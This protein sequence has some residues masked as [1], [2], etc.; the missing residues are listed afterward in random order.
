MS[1]TRVLPLC[2]LSIDRDTASS[3]DLDASY[4]F[5]PFSNF[6]FFGR[7]LDDAAVIGSAI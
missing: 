3:S 1:F 6:G 5:G 4:I 2:H 7:T